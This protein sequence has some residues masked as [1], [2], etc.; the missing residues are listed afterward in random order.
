M[1]RKNARILAAHAKTIAAGIASRSKEPIALVIA[2]ELGPILFPETVEEDGPP[3]DFAPD[4][5]WLGER[6]CR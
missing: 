2:D 4:E 5:I 6:P 1:T 3:I